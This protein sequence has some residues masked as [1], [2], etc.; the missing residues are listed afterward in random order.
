MQKKK[1]IIGCT[2]A[3]CILIIVG[4]GVLRG[5][6]S[7]Y[8]RFS[9]RREPPVELR[10]AKVL[11]GENIFTR[12]VFLKLD[13]TRL[14]GTVKKNFIGDVKDI[15]LLHTPDGNR[16][17]VIA[18]TYGAFTL[19]D[20]GGYLS[21]LKYNFESKKTPFSS[22]EDKESTISKKTLLG[23]I[24]I[25]DI[26]RDGT[27]EFF[28]R[29]G[30][31]GAAIFDF[32]GDRRWQYDRSE[33]SRY[34][35]GAAVG[36]L[37]GDKQAEIVV[38]TEN[39]EVFNSQ[40]RELSKKP[41]D[42]A[43]HHLEVMDTNHDGKA[44]IVLSNFGNCEIRDSQGEL[45]KDLDLPFYLSRFDLFL[46]PNLKEVQA[47]AAED[48]AFWILDLNGNAPT[49]FEAP[50]SEIKVT[51]Y[52][53]VENVELDTES[54]YKAN[55]IW[56]ELEKDKGK[57]LAVVA[58]FVGFDRSLFYFYNASGKL[59]YQEVLPETC[60]SIIAVP[61]EQGNKPPVLFVGGE[62]TIWSYKVQ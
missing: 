30:L 9:F 42:G 59:I 37:D 54:V 19:D 39:L 26:D 31:D 22:L 16:Q 49:K 44:E 60:Y 52:Q 14:T 55:S 62:K 40:G 10:D 6:Y 41:I 4:F 15:T 51:P 43:Y 35:K 1:I 5:I 58:Q 46:A 20:N 3:S 21:H 12:D 50:L 13:D 8:K 36:D 29:G 34:L 38:L 53:V 18:G 33:E 61:Q 32:Q 24:Q 48:R 17:F 7:L 47:L 23:D 28:A 45:I 11:I 27:P 2:L 56:V 25:I 57:Y